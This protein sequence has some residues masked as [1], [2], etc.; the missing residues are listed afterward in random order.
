MTDPRTPVDELR[1]LSTAIDELSRR[2]DALEAP[3]RI[4]IY[5]TIDD[6]LTRLAALEA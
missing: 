3:S 5:R 1:A 2:I 4:L 6:I